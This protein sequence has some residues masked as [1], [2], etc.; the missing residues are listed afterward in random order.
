MNNELMERLNRPAI[1]I[2]RT[3]ISAPRKTGKW[4][5]RLVEELMLDAIDECY[6]L[7]RRQQPIE[8]ENARLRREVA[9]LR[10]KLDDTTIHELVGGGK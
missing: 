3:K 6:R 2:W 1:K 5:E 9:Y 7:Q 8:E 10:R 4:G